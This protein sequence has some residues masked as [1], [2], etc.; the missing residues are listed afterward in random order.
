MKNRAFD[1]IVAELGPCVYR[2]ALAKTG[3]TELAQDIYQQTFLLLYEKQPSFNYREQL[4]VWLIRT[5]C[6]LA[7]GMRRKYD[8]SKTVSLD[9]IEPPSTGD[10]LSFEF[11]DMLSRLPD[12]L[13][14]VT[15]LYYIEDMPVADVARALSLS[16]SAVKVRLHRARA[17]LEKIYKEEI[18]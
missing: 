5:A 11:L 10:D 17:I 1:K 3:D 7:S 8:S 16:Q 9:S 2:T 13:R 6:K 18:L 15:V 14:D 12:I 4:Q